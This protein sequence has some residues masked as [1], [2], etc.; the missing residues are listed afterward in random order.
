VNAY[1]KYPPDG[2]DLGRLWQIAFWIGVIIMVVL[3]VRW[4]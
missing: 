4:L 1:K 3:L 2:P